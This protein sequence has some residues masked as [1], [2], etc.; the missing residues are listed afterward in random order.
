MLRAES[1]TA[2]VACMTLM[3][4]PDLGSFAKAPAS[5]LHEGAKFVATLSHPCF[6]PR[7]REYET[8]A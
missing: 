4:T 3:T 1:A 8:K 7:Y 5:V 2:A 6:W